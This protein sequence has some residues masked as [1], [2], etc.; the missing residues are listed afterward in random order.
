LTII[1]THAHLVTGDTGAYP[2]SP[3]SGAFNPDDLDDPMT[4]ERLLGE[5]DAAGI[6][7]AVLVQRASIY[8][9][10]SSYVCDSATRFPNRLVAVCS[11]DATAADCADSVRHW[12]SE[13]G[14]TGIRLME[15][16]KGMDIGWLDS[17]L[18]R[19]AWRAAAGLD[20][21]V[22]V[23]FFPWNRVEGLTRLDAIMRDIPGLTVVIDHFAA[24]KSDAGPPD[25]GVDALLEAVAAHEGVTIKFTTIPL[26]R[27]DEAGIDY[28]PVVA[29]MKDLFGAERMM[30]GSDITQSPGSY[31][32]MAVLGRRAVEKMS[33]AEQEQILGGTA[34]RVYGKG[35]A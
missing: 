1:D 18:A 26:G 30:W 20:V 10:D 16:V 9:F 6:D 27:L 19:E 11:I 3:P 24:I 13:R 28:R 21:P 23:H 35:W 15:M 31:E 4:V 5:M 7:K 8:G 29:R 33:A 17:P 34:R 12:V 2:P 14:A 32:Q 25:H 22:C